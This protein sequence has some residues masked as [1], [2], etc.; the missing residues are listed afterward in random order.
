MREYIL[1]FAL[2]SR[3]ACA[4]VSPS[5]AE[6][7]FARGFVVNNGPRVIFTKGHAGVGQDALGSLPRLVQVLI[8]QAGYLGDPATCIA[9]RFVELLTFFTTWLRLMN[10]FTLSFFVQSEALFTFALDW[11]PKGQNIP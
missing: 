10:L 1:T 6:R 8:R 4:E 3:S 11:Q 9:P 7:R 2:C 5:P